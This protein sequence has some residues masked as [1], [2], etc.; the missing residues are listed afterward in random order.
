MTPPYEFTTDTLV[1]LLEEIAKSEP[2]IGR[3]GHLTI[4]RFTTGWKCIL[5]TPHI[6]YQID[7]ITGG[8]DPTSDYGRIH[9]LPT[10][11]SLAAA[12]SACISRSQ[13]EDLV[14]SPIE[15]K[16]ARAIIK[17][18][19]GTSLK[20]QIPVGDYR[21]DLA[22]PDRK[23]A[24]ECDGHAYH[25]TK[26]QRT[27]DARRDRWLTAQGWRVVRCTGTEIHNDVAKVV[28]DIEAVVNSSASL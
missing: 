12:V 16:L 2:P 20:A 14:E 8:I 6:D 24:I 7:P 25:R 28:A 9:D 10:E 27:H 26:E 18:P 23:I 13:L 3:G 19:W 17:E 4:F 1:S 15:A 11:A 21:L 22:L 5:G